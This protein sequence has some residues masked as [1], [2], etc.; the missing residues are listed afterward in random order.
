MSHNCWIRVPFSWFA[1]YDTWVT[2]KLLRRK[3]SLLFWLEERSPALSE[4]IFRFRLRLACA[5]S[6]YDGSAFTCRDSPISE[7][8]DFPFSPANATV[9]IISRRVDIKQRAR[10]IPIGS[11]SVTPVLSLCIYFLRR[12]L[13]KVDG[14]NSPNS[15]P[16]TSALWVA[17]TS[18]MMTPWIHD[19]RYFAGLEQSRTS[20]MPLLT[21]SKYGS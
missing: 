19:A 9:A 8:R 15:L 16:S 21:G 3:H 10:P 17:H 12:T 13:P 11:E 18:L 2:L 6:G 1:P 5:S 20:Q 14:L 4:F 7:R